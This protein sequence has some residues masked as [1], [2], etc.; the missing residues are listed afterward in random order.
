CRSWE[1]VSLSRNLRALLALKEGS[2]PLSPAP[3]RRI[4][5]QTFRTT[6]ARAM[7]QLSASQLSASQLSA[8]QTTALARIAD[9]AADHSDWCATIF[10]YGE[11]AWREY[12][13]CA[14]Y[15]EKLRSEGFEVEEGS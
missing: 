9:R 6:G 12:R 7:S 1:K 13:S 5:R 2:R 10:S 14:W 4:F 8:A 15:V 3:C 11:T